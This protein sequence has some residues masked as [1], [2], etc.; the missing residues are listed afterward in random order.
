VKSFRVNYQFLGAVQE[1][2][3]VCVKIV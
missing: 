2:I 3:R 1:Y